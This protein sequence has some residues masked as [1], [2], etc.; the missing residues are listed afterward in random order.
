MF[1]YETKTG[2][3]RWHVEPSGARR[4]VRPT[5]GH[6]GIVTV[7]EVLGP[8]QTDPTILRHEY[9]DGV[10]RW[11]RWIV[12][13][14][15][16]HSNRLVPLS[17]LNRVLGFQPGSRLR[18]FGKKSSGLGELTAAQSAELLELYEKSPLRDGPR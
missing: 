11:W 14:N 3:S 2:P 4:K 12:P 1:V 18:G 6:Q 17:D 5:R 10:T 7:G 9:S 8:L 15:A 16:V 13:L